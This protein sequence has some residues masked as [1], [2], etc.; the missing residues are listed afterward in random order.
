MRNDLWL[1]NVRET[2]KFIVGH[3]RSV[4]LNTEPQVRTKYFLTVRI[5]D[6][7]LMELLALKCHLIEYFDE[8]LFV[9]NL[10]NLPVPI[11]HTFSFMLKRCYVD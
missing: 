1:F 2:P 3:I 8:K 6:F 4:P 5:T 9:E 10:V 11:C 7:K